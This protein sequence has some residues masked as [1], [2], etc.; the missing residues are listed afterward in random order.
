VISVLPGGEPLGFRPV[1]SYDLATMP[2][3]RGEPSLYPETLLDEA[4]EGPSE[5]QWCVFYTRA[6]QEKALARELRGAEIAFYLPLV[7]K[8]STIGRRKFTSFAPLFG[9]YVFAC[10]S[11]PERVRSLATNRVARVLAVRD[12]EQLI[13][14]LRQLR[15]LIAAEVPLTVEARLRPGNRVR[16]RKGPFAGV[17]GIVMHRRG[18]TRLLV[19]INFLQKGASVEIDDYLLEPLD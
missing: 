9:G 13:Q 12:P 2:I 3:L 1:L 6:R 7:K 17:E 19:S 15:Q 16:V 8:T 11:E 18:Q 10:V 4:A 5:R 14:D